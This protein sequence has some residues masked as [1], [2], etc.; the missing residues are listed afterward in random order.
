MRNLNC[1]PPEV[2][3]WLGQLGENKTNQ[4]W[5]MQESGVAGR[6]GRS[7]R[8]RA[9]LATSSALVSAWCPTT[10]AWRALAARALRSARNRARCRAVNVSRLLD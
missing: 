9:G 1:L 4:C 3:D 7:V 10:R 5:M 8:C 6:T 2:Q